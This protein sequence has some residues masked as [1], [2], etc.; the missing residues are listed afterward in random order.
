[1]P[2]DSHGT[3]VEYSPTFTDIYPQ[4]WP[5][6]VAIAAIAS[7]SVSIWD[8]SLPPAQDCW[9]YAPCG[10]E[11][12]SKATHNWPNSN[13]FQ[14]IKDKEWYL[15]YFDIWQSLSIIK[16][17]WIIK[18]YKDGIIYGDLLVSLQFLRSKYRASPTN[19]RSSSQGQQNC[20]CS[21]RLSPSY[22]LTPQ[23]YNPFSLTVS[24]F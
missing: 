4:K 19:L 2:C 16:N 7:P 17:H 15:I 3:M 21:P 22:W 13:T 5:S 9:I 24:T 12:T 23:W 1:M 6:F 20:N 11:T 18:I 14:I 8:G 10:G